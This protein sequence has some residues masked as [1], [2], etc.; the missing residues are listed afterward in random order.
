[1]TTQSNPNGCGYCDTTAG[2]SCQHT[3]ETQTYSHP[4]DGARV[5]YVDLMHPPTR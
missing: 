3:N 1:M 5:Q 2:T 4:S